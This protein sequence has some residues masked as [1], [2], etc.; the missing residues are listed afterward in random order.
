VDL[1]SE[2]LIDVFYRAGLRVI[3]VGVESADEAVLKKIDR[4]PIPV[5]KQERITRYCDKLGI[6]MTAFYVLGLPDDSPDVIRKTVQYAKHLNTHA[7]MF[8]LATPFPGT[9]Y[10][11]MVKDKLLHHDYEKMDCFSPVVAHPQL[12]PEELEK[13]REWA[14]VSYYYRP[15]WFFAFLRRIWKDFFPTKIPPPPPQLNPTQKIPS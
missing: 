5:E 9:D 13:L 2:E 3:N 8:Y 6:R 14:Y 4:I 7:A 12:S 10:Y 11:E 1:L 15:K